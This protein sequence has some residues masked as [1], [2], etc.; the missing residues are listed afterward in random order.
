[1]INR[2]AAILLL[3]ILSPIFLI[4]GLLIF[5]Q[6]GFPVFFKQKRDIPIYGHSRVLENLNRR[7]DYIFE[8]FIGD[9]SKAYVPST[10]L[11]VAEG[12]A[13]LRRNGAIAVLAHPVLLKDHIR[14]EV[15]AMDFDGIEAKYYRNQEGDEQTY[16][17]YAKTHGIIITAGSDYH[18][19]END[20]KHGVV[21]TVFMDGEDTK[22]FLDALQGKV[23]L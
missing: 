7:F 4:V 20:T 12:V 15:L 8:N 9:Q 21:G 6:D 19:I 11:P 16:R 22:E 17:D 3:I 13:L 10:Q 14:D 1:M 23:I 18:G 2:V 5:I